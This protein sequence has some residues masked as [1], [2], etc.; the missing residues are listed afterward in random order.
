M[1]IES[2]FQYGKPGFRLQPSGWL[3][4]S[5]VHLSSYSGEVVLKVGLH[6]FLCTVKYRAQTYLT[7]VLKFPLSYVSYH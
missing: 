2:L 4:K 7:S 6:L 5:V 1:I 3:Y